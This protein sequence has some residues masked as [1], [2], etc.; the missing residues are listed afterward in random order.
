MQSQW[1]AR[2]VRTRE[3]HELTHL[4]IV[5]VGEEFANGLKFPGDQNGSG[6]TAANLIN[7]FCVS[8]PMV[9]SVSPALQ[10]HRAWAQSKSF[11]RYCLEVEAK[12]AKGI[13]KAMQNE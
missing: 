2:L 12:R 8:K 10:A 13:A 11:E 9:Q 3:Q 6:S 4:Q 1:M 7:C 5:D